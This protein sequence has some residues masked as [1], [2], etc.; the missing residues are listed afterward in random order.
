VT[1]IHGRNS[2]NINI[3]DQQS[4]YIDSLFNYLK[5]TSLSHRLIVG[6]F[7]AI[8]QTF[9]GS[10]HTSLDYGLTGGVTA[11]MAG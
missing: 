11:Q 7:Y 9:S 5:L 6:P 10:A 3:I 2:R 8:N 4:A 1:D